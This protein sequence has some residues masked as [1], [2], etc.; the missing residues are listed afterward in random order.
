MPRYVVYNE[1]GEM[2]MEW[3]AKEIVIKL[4]NGEIF[5]AKD[6]LEED[7]YTKM[8]YLDD[9]I[10]APIC[11]VAYVYVRRGVETKKPTIKVAQTTSAAPKA[12]TNTVTI[13]VG[14]E[15]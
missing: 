6:V 2:V 9:T 15:E 10:I 7:H 4:K 12:D 13:K 3:E 5:S 11:S 1:N 14:E 8:Y